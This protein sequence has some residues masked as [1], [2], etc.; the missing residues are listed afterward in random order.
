ME[1]TSVFFWGGGG[2]KGCSVLCVNEDGLW[3]SFGQQK[4]GVGRFDGVSLLHATSTFGQVTWREG[5][6]VFSVEGKEVVGGWRGRRL[7][8]LF[9]CGGLVLKWRMMGGW[10]LLSL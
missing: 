9:G 6:L 8:R 10:G 4:Y 3:W 5:R 1:K 2:G 7:G